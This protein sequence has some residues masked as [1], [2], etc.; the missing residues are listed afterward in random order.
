M[1]SLGGTHA[2]GKAS[3][4][5]SSHFFHVQSLLDWTY[6]IS[7]CQID[8]LFESFFK[9]VG[10][11]LLLTN[12]LPLHFLS[13]NKSRVIPLKSTEIVPLPDRCFIWECETC[14]FSQYWCGG[15]RS[16]LTVSPL[17]PYYT[18]EGLKLSSCH[19]HSTKLCFS[20]SSKIRFKCFPLSGFP[21][22]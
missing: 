13:H 21:N 17:A 18:H 16:W 11:T 1:M 15:L 8:W 4:F 2:K 14:F 10:V 20:W 22:S 3:T 7:Y 19:I 12:S 6:I 5:P 9:S